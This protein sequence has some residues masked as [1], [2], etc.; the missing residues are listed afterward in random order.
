[1]NRL[2][3]SACSGP[4]DYWYKDPYYGRGAGFYSNYL[5]CLQQLIKMEE[6]YL[7]N[8]ELTVVPYIDWSQSCFVDNNGL[9]ERK[10]FPEN[11]L[12]A[13]YEW[14]Q[15][16][17]TDW[18]GTIESDSS[19]DPGYL[20]HN[21]SYYRDGNTRWK[22]LK[23]LDNKYN[24]LTPDISQKIQNVWEQ[25]FSNHVVLGIMA[26]GS[27]YRYNHNVDGFMDIDYYLTRT[28]EILALHPEITKIYLVT[29]DG[30]WVEPFANTFESLFYF[31]DVSRRTWQSEEYIKSHPHW[32]SDTLQPNHSVIHGAEC[33]VQARLL[34]KCQVLFGK[35]S[36][37]INAAMLFNDDIQHHYIEG[38]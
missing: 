11:T 8:G 7:V 29:D 24:K 5:R 25:E 31:K 1:M 28:K 9:A 36:G 23:E 13:W 35:H 3:I 26:R 21:G 2:L 16:P 18:D 37:F 20:D 15:K 12:N 32:W 17:E 10:P 34:A 27:E 19:Y 4:R 38:Y 6:D 33:L 14:F 30:N 22:F